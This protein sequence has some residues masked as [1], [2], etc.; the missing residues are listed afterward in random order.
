M[1]YDLELGNPGLVA[2][3]SSG[4]NIVCRFQGPGTILVQS[5]Q[6]RQFGRWISQVLP[7]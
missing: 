1:R 7:G 2:A 5:R 3:F 6:P 4:E